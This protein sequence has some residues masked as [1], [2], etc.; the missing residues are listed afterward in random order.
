MLPVLLPW[1][2]LIL[3]AAA[4]AAPPVITVPVDVP[5]AVAAPAAGS[6]ASD[7]AALLLQAAPTLRPEALSAALEAWIR[8]TSAGQP[9]RPIL[10]VID[11]GLPSTARRLWVFDMAQHRLIFHELVAHGRGSGEDLAR[12]F[13]NEEG[14]LMSSLG[15]FVTGETYVGKNGYSLRLRGLEPGVNDRAEARTIVMHGAPYVTDEF[16]RRV[17]RLGRS[18]GCP[19]LRPE[20]A[21]PLID[22]IKD[23]SLLYVWSPAPGPAFAGATPR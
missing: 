23:R 6:P 9:L 16:A 8:V 4:D 17:G 14:S 12:F 11:Y 22:A 3:P 5:A 7:L 19:A 1:I 13:S 21:R 15:A 18:H 2:A 10:T 20:I